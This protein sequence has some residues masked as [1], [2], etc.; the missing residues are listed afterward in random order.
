MLV[1]LSLE[2][3]WHFPI[4]CVVFL[5]WI[6]DILSILL[7]DSGSLWNA[8]FFFCF[9]RQSAQ[10]VLHFVSSEKSA[11]FSKVLPAAL[12]LLEALFRGWSETVS[13]I[14][15]P[16]SEPLG[17]PTHAQFSAETGACAG[18]CTE[19]G[20]PSSAISAAGSLPCLLPYEPSL[21]GLLARKTGFLLTL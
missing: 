11:H 5:D 2:S 17:F 7:L 4:P 14:V 21:P 9:T 15:V 16:L 10:S 18:S 6:L 19:S 12:G 3:W 1:V 8:Q 20:S 13:Y